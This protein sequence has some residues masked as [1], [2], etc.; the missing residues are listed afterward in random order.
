MAHTQ[1]SARWIEAAEA[2]GRAELP[3]E[4]SSTALRMEG[5]LARSLYADAHALEGES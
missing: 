1:W 5:T 3:A 2:D 4:Q